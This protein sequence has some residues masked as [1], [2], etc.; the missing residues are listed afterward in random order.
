MGE[1]KRLLVMA[2]M[3]LILGKSQAQQLIYGDDFHSLDTSLWRIEMERKPISSV[4]IRDSALWLDCRGGATMW[5]RKLLPQNFCIEYDRMVLMEG[6]PNDRLS[7]MNQF[8]MASDNDSLD[9]K[10]RSGSFKSYDS[11]RMYYAG[12]GGNYNKTVRL[13]KYDGKGNR[14]LLREINNRGY[15]LKAGTNY[16]IRIRMVNGEISLWINGI[17]YFNYTDP[18]PLK[19]GYFAFR[20]TWSRQRISHFR[21]YYMK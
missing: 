5:F 3:L 12:I 17:L 13:R 9:L 19:Y 10:H 18:M 11:L 14:L 4:Y 1:V 21:L 6:H 2:F 7:D 20:S 15:L 16:H 8:W